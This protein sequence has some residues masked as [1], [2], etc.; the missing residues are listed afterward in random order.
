M[1]LPKKTSEEIEVRIQELE[2]QAEDL[3]EEASALRAILKHEQSL[4]TVEVLEAV[5]DHEPVGGEQGAKLLQEGMRRARM[6]GEDF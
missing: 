1:T 4:Q 5:R 2:S 3:L 6:R